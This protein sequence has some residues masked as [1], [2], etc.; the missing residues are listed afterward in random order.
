[1]DQYDESVSVATVHTVA[2]VTG[3]DVS[4]LP[5]L[6]ESIDPDALDRLFASTGGERRPGSVEFRYAG[7]LVTITNS[8]DLRI[9][10]SDGSTMVESRCLSSPSS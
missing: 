5:P 1:M 6:Y 9:T 4:M 7:Y 2:D 3:N 10:V 8:S